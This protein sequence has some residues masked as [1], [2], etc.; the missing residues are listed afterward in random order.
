MNLTIILILILIFIILYIILVEIFT[1]AFR[2]TGLTHEK[3][4]FQVISLFTNAGFTTTESE[5]IPSSPGRRRL[6]IATMITGH[7]FSAI[8]VSLVVSVFTNLNTVNELKDYTTIILISLGV[9]FVL[10]I[11][12]K[13]PFISKHI[14]KFLENLAIKQMQRRPSKNVITELDNYGKYSI[15]EVLINDMPASLVDKSLYE[16]DLKSNYNIN[17][18]VLR[19]KNKV[20]DVSANTI[21][22]KGDLIVVF[23]PVQNIKDLFSLT[24]K[25]QE[26][27][28][29]ELKDKDN[30]ISIIDN[31]GKEA[32]VEIRVNK[33]PNFMVN[34]SLFESGLK[35]KYGLNVM[36]CK[37]KGSINE[38]SK[39]T[40][41][42]EGDTIMVFGQ[43]KII[44]EAFLFNT[45][46]EAE[47]NKTEE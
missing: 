32:M 19:R 22:Q 10:I 8:I 39:D 13:V 16:S 6:A 30:E 42:I 25:E 34:K 47:E 26:E 21:L 33:V 4:R 36:M 44:K 2:L 24:K 14:S 43:Y 28:I 20:V 7:I 3:A 9:F 38:I 5:I 46:D 17:L 27:I 18:L 12:L 15:I 1:T 37:R 45:S 41:I 29:A 11:V 23:G 31:Y 35:D 40:I